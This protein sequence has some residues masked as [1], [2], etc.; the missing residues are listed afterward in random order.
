M[1]AFWPADLVISPITGLIKVREHAATLFR[2]GKFILLQVCLTGRCLVF[3]FLRG[4]SL[5]L[6]AVMTL[7]AHLL[8]NYRQLS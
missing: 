8:V 5:E 2:H 4:K 6:T 1:I 3:T 7:L